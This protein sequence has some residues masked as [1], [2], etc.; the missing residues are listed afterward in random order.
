MRLLL[1]IAVF[2]FN[3]QAKSFFSN[4]EQK[5]SSYFIG[6]LKELLIS[7]QK[8]RGLTNSYLNGNT[9]ALLLV[10]GS[11][12]DMKQAIGKMEAT[13]LAADPVINARMQN[14]SNALL[15]LNH[16]ALKQEA[17]KTFSEYTEKIQEILMFA[18]TVSQRS[19]KELNPFGKEG[20]QIMMMTLLPLTE[21][22]G[23]L[24]GFG[25]GLAS[26]NSISKNDKEQIY[27]LVHQATTLQ[28]KLQEQMS[29][30]SSKYSSKLPS[31]IHAE[32]NSIEK[33]T[34]AYTSL[35]S[36]KLLKSPKDVDPD[37]F[38]DAGT[39]II[40]AIVKLYNSINNAVLEDAK[41]WF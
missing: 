39:D 31:T 37:V 23:Q 38:F 24:R 11:R 34:E 10:Y 21:A 20:S 30:L 1:I 36:K 13:T 40:D 41:G 3:L 8:T 9:A 29:S 25:S 7:T 4:D 26:K 32:L 17:K 33:K 16:K 27:L 6:S 22:I 2:L 18:Q 28:K 19:S 15:K 35:A 5:Q 12:D 14:I